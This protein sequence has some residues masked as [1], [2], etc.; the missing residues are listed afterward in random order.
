MWQRLCMRIRGEGVWGP[1]FYHYCNLV[2]LLH[3]CLGECLSNVILIE[4]SIV[5]SFQFSLWM[6][7]SLFL[8][9]NQS[10]FC[11]SKFLWVNT[12]CAWIYMNS[13]LSLVFICI[14]DIFCPYSWLHDAISCRWIIDPP[15]D[16]TVPSKHTQWPDAPPELPSNDEKEKV[17]A[18]TEEQSNKHTTKTKTSR[19]RRSRSK[20]KHDTK[21]I[22]V[23]VSTHSEQTEIWITAS[24]NLLPCVYTRLL[25]FS[26]K[27]L[28]W[29]NGEADFLLDTLII[30][31]AF[32]VGQHMCIWVRFS[33]IFYISFIIFSYFSWRSYTSVHMKDEREIST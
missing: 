19:S 12:N 2:T 7:R 28:D 3:V 33:P 14:F 23:Q 1:Y 16:I 27:N 17:F 15:L 24:Q 10:G 4:I 21:V 8:G 31:E 30:R 5:N 22:G 13:K 18:G 9:S 11:T 26:D 20:R 25:A 6:S 29:L 32:M